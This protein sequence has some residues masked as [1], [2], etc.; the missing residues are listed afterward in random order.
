M[1]PA[2]GGGLSE[3]SYNGQPQSRRSIGEESRA[4]SSLSVSSLRENSGCASQ[5][6]V[7]KPHYLGR[8]F[9]SSSSV[10]SNASSNPSSCTPQVIS[11]PVFSSGRRQQRTPSSATSHSIG[12]TTNSQQHISS[13]QR[14]SSLECHCRN[15]GQTTSSSSKHRCGR[16]SEEALRPP[17]VPEPNSSSCAWNPL[18][19]T[20]QKRSDS[21]LSNRFGSF[22]GSNPKEHRLEDLH[23]EEDHRKG[24]QQ[25]HLS[26]QRDP[27]YST[28]RWSSREELLNNNNIGGSS[29]STSLTAMADAPK[30]GAKAL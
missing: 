1:K 15:K 24:Q 23:E 29:S 6:T 28:S 21:P 18:F 22:G 8:L 26:A 14:S 12:S 2:G 20:S 17:L 10:A 25:G 4:E 13:F 9:G 16:R 19:V 27:S 30:M 3:V 7:N 5:Q 11:A